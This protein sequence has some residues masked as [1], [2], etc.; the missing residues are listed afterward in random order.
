[1]KQKLIV[2]LVMLASFSYGSV[3][4]AEFF[5]SAALLQAEAFVAVIDKGDYLSAYASG[6]PFIRFQARQ[7]E[8]IADQEMAV[9]FLGKVIDR[10]LMTV[11]SRDSYPGLPDGNYLVVSY[12]SRTEHKVKAIEVLLLSQQNQGWQVCRYSVR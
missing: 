1:M 11:R 8:W 2:I 6:L 7:D 5:S 9:E 12:E 4:Q 3:V 10:Q